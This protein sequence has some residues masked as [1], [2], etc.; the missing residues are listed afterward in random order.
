MPFNFKTEAYLQKRGGALQVIPIRTLQETEE[1]K[2][3]AVVKLR[4]RDN[5]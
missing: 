3:F 2:R 1:L 5:Q 4:E